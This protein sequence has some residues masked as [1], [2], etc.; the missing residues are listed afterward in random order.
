MPNDHA[1]R[2]GLGFAD[3]DGDKMLSR[4]DWDYY[5]AAMESDN[6][7]LAIKLGGSGDMTAKS[8]RWKFHRGIPQLPSPLIY[9]NVLYMVNDG[10]GRVTLLNP[11]DGE[12][13]LQGRLPGSSDTFYASPVAGDGKVY[14][15]SEKGKVFVL[16]PGP[17]LEPIA[18]ND[19]GDS[20][21]ATPAL[22]D[23]R[24]YL[25]TLNTLY[26]FGK[27]QRQSRTSNLNPGIESNRPAETTSALGAWTSRPAHPANFS[28]NVSSNDTLCGNGPKSLANHCP[29]RSSTSSWR[30]PT[31]PGTAMPSNRTLKSA[32]AE[33]SAS[34]PG[35]CTKRS[36]G[37]WTVGLIEEGGSDAEP[38]NGQVAQR[39]YYALTPRGWDVLRDELRRLGA[40]VDH[41]R[42]NPRLRK[43]LV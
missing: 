22:V 21:Y 30:W 4:A 43:G 35:R 27:W 8:V 3:L 5:K 39:R 1:R 25:R 24:I 17:K 20:I 14:I 19:L 34:G 7:M 26:C 28:P 12:L 31:A 23:G 10:G 37:C 11:D 18:V 9:E 42:A 32:P 38:A 36:S 40:I 13:L 16:P 2:M 15:S 29:S 6:G 41:A 33:R